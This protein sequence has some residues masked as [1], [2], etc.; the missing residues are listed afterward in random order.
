MIKHPVTKKLHT[1]RVAKIASRF[2]MATMIA[3]QACD[4]PT[5]YAIDTGFYSSNDILFYNPDDECST[6]TAS[7]LSATTTTGSENVEK[8]LKYFTG[9]G[10]SLAAAAGFVGNMTQ[11]SSM[12]P[13]IIQGGGTASDDYIPVSGVGFGLIQWTYSSRQK[14][15]VE[16]A[17]STNRK[18]TDINLQL[19]Y[20][21][22]E[23][24]S[25]YKST[26]TALTKAYSSP[27][28]P[29][30]ATII[31]HGR[32]RPFMN[33]P[34]FQ[35]APTLGYEASGS[36]S[37]AE[38]KKR[39]VVP[40]EA[41][42][43]QYR[44]TIADGSGLASDTS[45]ID[46]LAVC[47]SSGSPTI[48]DGIAFPIVATKEQIQMGTDSKG[49]G[50]KT[51]GTHWCY[52][53]ITNCHHDYNAADIFAPTGTTVVST[54]D[55]TVNYVKR[56]GTGAG[57]GKRDAIS[58]KATDGTNW[59]FTHGKPNSTVVKEGQAVKAGDKIMEVGDSAAA[60]GTT[61]HVHVDKLPS[62]PRVSCSSASCKSYPFVNIQPILKSVF[63]KM[64]DQGVM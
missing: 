28:T 45:S 15:L 59:Y 11:E 10:L 16:L 6:S 32:T 20:I 29:A 31:I 14:P 5:V 33:E 64:K 4:I 25:T 37:Y 52:G 56:N 13:K 27:L 34:D 23:L 50:W 38:L 62:P 53:S 18:I 24:N 42:Y 36:T 61:P 60:D 30:Q 63:D 26:L 17:K 39:R 48:S 47:G 22:K 46:S 3:F 49:T 2:I 41:A 12:N 43:K 54:V 55:G 21:W 19:D 7:T 9:K 8:V 35:I 51:N 57:S 1:T 44:S 40:A 58:I